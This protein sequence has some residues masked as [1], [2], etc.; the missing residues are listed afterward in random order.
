MPASF[1]TSQNREDQTPE[2]VTADNPLKTEQQ[3]SQKDSADA[4]R[5][6]DDALKQIRLDAKQSWM[7]KR[8]AVV[9][10]ILKAFE[11]LKNNPYAVTNYGT[12]E[13]DPIAKVVAGIVKADESSNYEY[14]DNVYQM[15]CLSFMACLGPDVAKT[16]WMPN[17]PQEEDDLS[18][19]KKASTMM[20]EVERMNDFASLGYLEM[21]YFWTGG[22]YFSYVRNIVDA[23]RAG[24]S[25]KPVM[26]MQD[27]P[28]FPDRYLCPNCGTPQPAKQYSPFTKPSCFDCQ[29]P[30]GQKDWYPAESMP[31]PM[32]IDEIEQPN[33]MTAVDIFCSLNV[34]VDPDAS[35]LSKTPILDLEGEMD[36]AAVRAAYPHRYAE[37]APGEYSDA[38]TGSSTD[39]KARESVSS[40]AAAKGITS[41][42]RKGS[43]SRCWIQPW[44]FN[45]L[46]DQELAKRLIAKYPKGVKLVTYGNDVVLEKRPESLLEHWT[47]ARVIKGVG[48]N[49]FGVGDVAISVQDR[50]DDTANNIHIYMD[51]MALP[52]VL[53]NA[54][55]VDVNALGRQQWGGGRAIG[56]YPSMKTPGMRYSL[57]EALWQPTFHA[58]NKIYDYSQTLM[59]L[60]QLLT[61]VQPQ[62]FG[63]GTQK[64]VDTFG[65]QQQMLN[66]AMGRLMMFLTASRSE[67]AKR[68]KLCVKCMAN[69]IDGQR[70]IVVPS[71]VDDQYE[72]EYVRESDVQGEIHAFPD[73]DQGFPASYGEMRDRLLQ[74]LGMIEKNPV[75]QRMLN[76]PD[77]QKLLA[78]YLLPEGAKLPGDSER[79]K[80][81]LLLS[82]LANAQPI[83]QPDPASGQMMP[84]PSVQPD[85]DFDDFDMIVEIAKDWG[86][87]NYQ[88][89]TTNPN[90][91]ANVRAYLKLATIMAAKK[92]AQQAAMQAAAGQ[93]PEGQQAA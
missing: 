83:L 34:D 89:A 74:I 68:S 10:R 38:A 67:K 47:E 41:T 28:V 17:D 14:N 61:G 69:D 48:M 29:T 80:I 21:L 19:A 60:M 62:I 79:T 3:Q 52:P 18:F 27:V 22:T 51:R 37:I 5:E 39:R 35:E 84:M 36:S 90:G 93:P 8:Q 71:Q 6:E 59:M 23:V 7:S 86:Q 77:T 12:S 57:Q 44:A 75:L 16:R 43:F 91:Y 4:E 73:A 26:A 24:I 87:R 15:L 49:P 33:S 78:I 92:A 2:E 11:Y 25:K 31:M 50:I 64:G 30:L 40:P 58:D 55:L 63:A 65:G 20:A 56:V 53:A 66:T 88:L 81:K 1:L 54:A 46:K 82:Q 9:R 32:Q 45:A 76:D 13:M 70:R 42:E 85:P 72:N